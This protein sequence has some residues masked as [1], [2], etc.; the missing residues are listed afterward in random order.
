VT[1]W[2]LER[3]YDYEGC[4]ILGVYA[5]MGAAKAAAEEH[6]RPWE[7]AITWE[8]RTRGASGT[9]DMSGRYEVTEMQV[10]GKPDQPA[11]DG[12]DG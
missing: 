3:C 2:V 12:T 1:V 11:K 8:P 6:Y 7:G 4:D 10:E 9:S 5:T